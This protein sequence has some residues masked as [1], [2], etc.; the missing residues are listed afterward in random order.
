[1]RDR[2]KDRDRQADRQTQTEKD[3]A[4][5][6]EIYRLTYMSYSIAM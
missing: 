1:M 5:E 4:K 6:N 3:R 2:Q